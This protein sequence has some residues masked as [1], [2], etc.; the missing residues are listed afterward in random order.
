[1]KKIV[2]CLI[3]VFV[4]GISF[5]QNSIYLED[6]EGVSPA[7]TS[8]SSQGSSTVF[9]QNSTYAFSGTKSYLGGVLTSDTLFL[10]TA[11]I[12][13]STSTFLTLSFKQICKIDFFDKAI[14]QVSSDNGATWVTLTSNE[15]NG[16]GFLNANGFSS[17]SYSDWVAANG[18]ATPVNSWWKSESFDITAIA[19]GN[20]QVKIRFGVIDL[21]NNGARSNYG[22]LIDDINLIEAGCELVPPSITLSGTIFQGKVY[23]T[24]PFT[25]EADIRDSSG[26]DSAFVIYS[27][28]NGPTSSVMMTRVSGNIFRGN[29]PSAIVGDTICY[30]ISAIDSTTCKN[31]GTY[32]SLAC[33]QF[34][35]NAN[36]PPTCLGTP[37]FSFI[38]NETFSSF[39]A[40]NGQ[41]SVGIIGNNWEN[42][43]SGDNHDWFVYDQGTQSQ[44]TGP[45][46]DHSPLDANYMYVE[47]SNGNAN[48]TAILNTPCYDFTNL[49]SP[50]F[51]FWYHLYGNQMG[52]LRL[53]IYSGGQWVLDIMPVISGDQGDQWLFN[54]VDLTAYSGSV[55]KLRFRANTGAGFRSDIAID[56]IEI[57]EPVADD[58]SIVSVVSPNPAGC[59]GST[60]EF[61]TVELSNLG[62]NAQNEIPL[63]YVLNGGTVVRD[64]A[65][66]NMAPGSTANHSFQ[67]TINMSVPGSY[68]F[69]I[70]TELPADGNHTND[71]VFNY[72]VASSLINVSFPDTTN[73]DNFLTGV[74]GTFQ[75]GWANSQ[76][77]SHDWYVNT[78]GTASGQTG[79]SGDNTSGGGQY[80]YLEATNFNNLEAV[81]Y[82]KCF[83]ISSL[84]KPEM[85]FSYHMSGVEMGEL[86]VDV[87][88][89]GFEIRDVIS[90]IVGD[91]GP[92]WNTNIVDLSAFKG[93]VKIVFRGITG[94]GYRS[95]IAVDDFSLRDA[96]PVGLTEIVK[97]TAF[98][99]YPNPAKESIMVVSNEAVN[100]FEIRDLTGKEVSVFLNN[101]FQFQVD[102]SNLA[103]G[104]YFVR[105]FT[106][107]GSR[108]KKLIIE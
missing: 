46:Q 18:S 101:G 86:H 35:I 48:K 45:S 30:S 61:L 65:R 70:W 78:G 28:N 73:F 85:T 94:N 5:A 69:D 47:S 60:A 25:I 11:T 17:I 33:L 68:S 99:V 96:S 84:N 27:L 66:I 16:S 100:R 105:V 8:Y 108:T 53:D 91:Q 103:S 36:P 63:A 67:Q 31:V 75:D 10:E 90:P 55:V 6:F 81:L 20:S 49:L 1:M 34:D 56:D 102:L 106:E 44:G 57:F 77:D 3:A 19:A 29:I 59:S 97:E 80:V 7:V 64:T 58:I 32:P 74:P 13:A 40:G 38:Y 23:N 51:R 82:S 39:S 41:N 14:V 15:Y 52:D 72:A 62:G 79:P 71:S 89:N 98:S 12:N 26:V 88:I 9:S 37:V 42:E 2:L 95:D 24:G 104:I 4:A 107:N 92:N 50:K 83:D 21:D 93:V 43:V 22:W 87:I 76:F 54:E